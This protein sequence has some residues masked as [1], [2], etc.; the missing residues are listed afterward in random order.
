MAGKGL[1]PQIHCQQLHES[2]VE[3]VAASGR[4]MPIDDRAV[5]DR[6][7]DGIGACAAASEKEVLDGPEPLGGPQQ[8][9]A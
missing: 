9:L 7:L 5:R 1:N 8:L 6:P 3:P 4:R 2:F